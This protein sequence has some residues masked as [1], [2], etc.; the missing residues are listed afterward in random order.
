M[1]KGLMFSTDALD[2][3]FI[4]YTFASSQQK[5]LLIFKTFKNEQSRIN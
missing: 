2:K 5:R 3:F 4:H 1:N